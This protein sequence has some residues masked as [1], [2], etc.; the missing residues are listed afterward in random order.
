MQP[1]VIPM[2]HRW[3]QENP[4]TISLAQGAVSYSPPPSVILAVTEPEERSGASKTV[5]LSSL[6]QC[7]QYGPV[8]GNDALREAIAANLRTEKEID[9]TGRAVYCTAGSNMAF[10]ATVLSISCVGDEII[11]NTPFYFNH[12]MAVRIAGCTPVCVPTLPNFQPDLTAIAEAV[13]PKT[14]AIVT[15]SPNN[16][17]GVVYTPEAIRAVNKLC[18]SSGVYHIHDEA[19]EHFV[20]GETPHSSPLG[21]ANSHE[22]TVGLFSFSKAYAMAGWRMGYAVVPE[23]LEEPLLKVQ[24]T[25]LIC[26]TILSQQLALEAI[27]AGSPW[28]QEQI[29]RLSRVRSE[30]YTQ[31]NSIGGLKVAVSDGA[32]YFMASLSSNYDDLEIVRRLICDYG[33]AVLPGSAFGL[34]Q[35]RESVNSG[36]RRPASGAVAER[37]IRISFG[38]VRPSEVREAINRLDS[39]IRE[40]SSQ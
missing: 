31:L 36:T 18:G 35:R 23:H 11:L 3:I 20:F 28:C 13:T 27:K 30:M 19:Y 12:E 4:R 7:N 14:R 39:G 24:D 38:A 15:V 5:P 32:L 22:H 10:F 1:P 25:N 17:T 8:A 37:F 2:L 21:I 40:L 6:S 34:G 9:T 29:E 26:P 16:P 33:V